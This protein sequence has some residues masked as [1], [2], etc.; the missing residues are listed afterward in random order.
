MG[1]HLVDGRREGWPPEILVDTT[2]R[3]EERPHF[4][5]ARL[6]GQDPE[7]SACWRG[8]Q[9]VDLTFRISAGVVADF[10]C[11]ARPRPARSSASRLYPGR[12]ALDDRGRTLRRVA[13]DR[14][15]QSQRWLAPP[16]DDPAAVQ[17][18]RLLVAL[19]LGAPRGSACRNAH[20]RGNSRAPNRAAI[21]AT[22][23]GLLGS[24]VTRR[25]GCWPSWITSQATNL[26]H[27]RSAAARASSS[28]RTPASGW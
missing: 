17:E 8:E 24:A 25:T 2:V 9:A 28:S 20:R 3:I 11:F 12:M 1:R 5:P 22:S 14:R 4:A 26:Q 7:F 13:R 10:F 19:E 21:G 15:K 23:S 27:C 16:A 18:D 6:F